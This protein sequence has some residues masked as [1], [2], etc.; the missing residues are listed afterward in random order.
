MH[1]SLIVLVLESI[2]PDLNGTFGAAKLFYVI[3]S[4]L[5]SMWLDR[6]LL[7]HRYVLV[8][9]LMYPLKAHYSSFGGENSFDDTRRHIHER[10]IANLV[11]MMLNKNKYEILNDNDT[12]G[13]EKLNYLIALHV[14]C[15]RLHRTMTFYALPYSSYRFSRQ[16]GFY[17]ELTSA[18]KLDRRIQTITNNN[19]FIFF[20][21]PLI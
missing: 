12:L 3:L 16:F 13:Y 11:C 2:Y 21:H 20:D 5:L 4:C 7:Q 15:L 14:G 17:Q 10:A 6:M 9:V 19:A 1:I 18:L 8:L